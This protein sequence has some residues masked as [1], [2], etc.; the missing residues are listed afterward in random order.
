[1][2]AHAY[3]GKTAIAGSAPPS[4]PSARAA[5]SAS[6]SRRAWP[7]WTTPA[8]GGQ[9]GDRPPPSPWRPNP[10]TDIPRSL[11]IKELTHFSR[12][13]FGGG[14]LRH[15][16]ARGHGRERGRGRLRALLPGVQRA[17]RPPLRHR[18]A[19]LVPGTPPRRRP[20][21]GPRRSACSRRPRGIAMFAARIMHEFGVTSEDFGRVAVADRRHAATN[22][23]RGSTSSPSPLEDHQNS[24][25]IVEPLHLLDCCQ[26]DRRRPGHPLVTSLERAK[27][28]RQP[29]VVIEGAA[30]GMYDDQQ[31]M[32]LFFRDEITGLPEMGV[33]QAALETSGLG[34]DDIQTAVIC[35]HF[36]PFSCPARGVRLL[37]PRGGQGLHRRRQR[38]ARRPPAHQHHGGQL[39]EGYL[40]GMNG[41]AEGVRQVR[42]RPHN[43]V[44]DVEHVLVTGGTGV[45]TSALLLGG[46]WPW[47]AVTH[48][49]RT[50]AGDQVRSGRP[51]ASR[52][53]SCPTLAVR[54]QPVL[55]HR[56]D[57][58]GHRRLRGIG[59]MIAAGFLANGATVYISSRRPRPATPPP[60]ASP[61]PTAAR[62][63][64]S[65]PTSRRSTASTAWSRPWPTSSGSTCW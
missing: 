57:R 14:A 54:R 19:G 3:A 40:H 62:A 6:P 43:Q 4:S 37:R 2:T 22:P 45:P 35:D 52:R 64:R 25:W 15:R 55:R 65:P 58:A 31:M 63:S 46:A 8:S 49:R 20:T 29:P 21:P 1:M 23:R 44:D 41:I 9:P 26:G 34:P 30:Q 50:A 39:G 32:R 61:R 11:G 47:R 28:L 10:E 13:H 36:T 48:R 17:Q 16:P 42:A 12:V 60:P 7:P 24:R 56:Q 33:R 53:T 18:R 5:S 59:E 51:P 27:D 38:R